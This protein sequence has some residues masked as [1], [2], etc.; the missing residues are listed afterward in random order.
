[1][2]FSIFT[3]VVLILAFLATVGCGS[4][5]RETA[6]SLERADRAEAAALMEMAAAEMDAP[7]DAEPDEGV[8]KSV[9]R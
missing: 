1:M 8:G 2:R 6:A 7:V 5:Q 9:L 4:A 3:Q